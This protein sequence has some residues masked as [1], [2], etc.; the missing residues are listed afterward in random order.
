MIDL[1]VDFS[2]VLGFV[3]K[4]E[5]DALQTELNLSH[6][7]IVNQ[8]GVGNDFLGWVDLPDTLDESL[9]Q[10][11]EKD[12][13]RISAIADIFVVIGIGGSYLGARAVNEALS[14]QFAH[15]LVSNKQKHPHVVFAGNNLSEDYL[16]DLIDVLDK[17]DYAM[18]VVS[19]SGTT[20]EPAIAFRILRAHIE[21]KYGKQEAR[22]RIFA[23]T[24]K[25]RG[26]LKKLSLD[27]GYTSYVVPDDIGGRY[28]V[29]T[30][31]GLLP[32]AVAGFDIRKMIEGAKAMREV[33]L[34]DAAISASPA[35]SYAA[36]R[37]ALYRK[38]KTTEIMVGY[39]PSLVFFVEWWKQLYG[40]SEGKQ[41]RG[42]F[43]AGV[44]FT[45]DLHSMGQYIQEGVRM[46]FE[47]VISVETPRRNLSVPVDPK[48]LDGLNFTAGKRLSEVNRQAELGTLLA[49]VD[50]G[51]P[52]IIINVPAINEHVIGQLVYFFEF[53]CALSG[54]MLDVNPFDQPGV[55]AYKKNMFA[56][57]GKPG[58]EKQAAELRARL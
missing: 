35:A 3:D 38:G 13:T 50:G 14:H 4:K 20:T 30:P 48:D 44:T 55:E 42:I 23:V 5:I 22:K 54:Y 52:N 31:V 33:C 58:Y 49:H 25:E 41:N 21:K 6:Q 18:A 11:I 34:A 10:S 53:A 26:V 37:T 47:T 28:S 15:L 29:L 36:T 16:S 19:K 12:A 27:E 32:I 24:D 56:L 51:V 2:N 40:E 43:P 39:Q 57:L 8:T 1:K 7:K 45:A 9:L 17:R 46:L